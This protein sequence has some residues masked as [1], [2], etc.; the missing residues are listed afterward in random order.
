MGMSPGLSKVIPLFHVPGNPAG[1]PTG[2]DGSQVAR[3][4]ELYC[5]GDA[6]HFS[7]PARWRP[8]WDVDFTAG[9]GGEPVGNDGS[10]IWHVHRST[11]QPLAD[12]GWKIHV[13]VTESQA[14]SVLKTVKRVCDEQGA[15][16]KHLCRLSTL[17]AMNSKAADRSASGKFVTV[18]PDDS[19]H[20]RD[21]ANELSE[22]LHGVQ[23]PHILSDCRWADGAPVFFRYGAFRSEYTYSDAGKRVYARRGKD[24]G[25]V[26]DSRSIPFS[27]PAGVSVPPFIATRIAQQSTQG[28]L[29]FHV[30]RAL[31]FS[32]TGGIYEGTLLE[33]KEPV[34]V[35]EARSCTGFYP[36]RLDAVGHLDH[37]SSILK[38]LG[39]LPFV[40]EVLEE[41]N[42]WEHRFLVLEKKRGISLR[43][44]TAIHHPALRYNSRQTDYRQY[45]LQCERVMD[46][47]HS[48]LMQLHARGT[49]HNDIHPGNVVIDDDLRVSLVDFEVAGDA[50]SLVPP[51]MACPGFVRSTGNG[52]Q[53]DLY[54][55]RVLG[56]WLM[57]PAMTGLHEA[58]GHLVEGYVQTA[59]R[60]FELDPDHFD[61]LI[62]SV[63]EHGRRAPRTPSPLLPRTEADLEAGR[64]LS[65]PGRAFGEYLMGVATPDEPWLFPCDPLSFSEPATALSVGYG[66]AGVMLAVDQ[67]GWG[68]PPDWLSWAGR[69]SDRIMAGRGTPGLWDGLA[70][71]A[72]FWAAVG[73][74][75]R[76]VEAMSR[77]KSELSGCTDLSLHSGLAGYGVAALK[78]ST[79]VKDHCFLAEAHE[80]AERIIT[81][82]RRQPVQSGQGGLLWGGSGI[83]RFLLRAAEALREPSWQD[84]AGDAIGRDLLL[85]E[86]DS[87]GCLQLKSGNRS[88]PYLGDGALGVALANVDYRAYSGA[89]GIDATTE[90]LAR[91]SM[92]EL[93]ID[94]SL[95]FGR[96]GI[97]YGLLEL[98]AAAGPSEF[99]L[100]AANWAVRHRQMVDLHTV[101]CGR[102][103]GLGGRGGFRLAADFA[104]GTAGALCAFGMA[105]GATKPEA[106]AL[107]DVM[108]GS[109]A[110]F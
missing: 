30:E 76:A 88:L 66:A 28:V 44:W 70:G 55:L 73:D 71:I 63:H 94:G 14:M 65:E 42:V 87:A 23:G 104:T 93:M 17:V 41:V 13:S 91:S 83:S 47:L 97:S 7:S 37:E 32:N 36:D 58:D 60:W 31:Q 102:G 77:A 56:L 3:S 96:A 38:D 5:F 16:Y 50:G 15:S 69:T 48:K 25:L 4:L 45:R 33:N 80:T 21:L 2:S 46:D 54:A 61:D 52:R 107:L 78:L 68:L 101:A 62:E 64:G 43:T 109:A 98:A 51:Q 53:R 8:S 81:A 86:A 108:T 20:F 26:E 82:Q 90:R 72:L 106:T 9:C 34:V 39:E 74:P 29:P 35:K 105:E 99:G 75:S 24:D 57:Y 19:E 59:I 22:A 85:C 6:L 95:A 11:V 79:L 84:A 110:G 27:I 40:P 92:V 18:Y 1:S 103:R 100:E 10:N 49:A 12:E 67:A 89:P